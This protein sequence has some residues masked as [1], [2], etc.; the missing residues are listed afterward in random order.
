MLK[1]TPSPLNSA[2][3]PS[4]EVVSAAL[5]ALQAELADERAARRATEAALCEAEAARQTAEARAARL[6]AENAYSA[7]QISRL[8]HLNKEL[9]KALFGPR[10]EKLN[11]DERQLS[12]EEFWAAIAEAGGR[13]EADDQ[14]QD[15]EADGKRRR[16]SSRG[17]RSG[18][19]FGPQVDR[20]EEVIEPDTI[21]CPC[22]CGKMTKIG[23]DRSERLDHEPAKFTVIE[24]VRP[25]YACNKCKSGG[26][27]QS[28][29]PAAL[30]EGGL[31]TE[32][33]LAQVLIA[34][35]GD[36]LPL[37]RQSQIYERSGVEVHRATLATWVGQAS[38]HLRPVVDCLKDELKK[39][40]H[41]GLDETTIR[42]LDP[43]RGKTK[44]GY[45]WTL[46][47]DERHWSG[48]DPPGVVYR[49]EPGRGG[50]Y[51]ARLLA[52]FS[53]T[54]QLDAYSG[55]K[56]LARPDR[57]GGPVTRALCW[58]H[59]AARTML[60]RAGVVALSVGIFQFTAT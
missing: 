43:G 36:H 13:P 23:E 42:V 26:V 32:A 30:V 38:F 9:R 45:M 56:I 34:K 54:V 39:S 33:F 2:G 7:E 25:R 18:V 53:G 31:P 37:Y 27:V 22:G 29:A 19:R 55:H 5:A 41:L 17:S 40:D 49:Y 47:R 58:G 10:S 15:E 35:Y 14:E 46:V 28:P 24:T 6:E 50:K 60:L 44:T 12:F 57:P 20:R 48:A 11:E 8:E 4:P 51:G 52:G 3:S 1:T 16:R 59:V 21:M